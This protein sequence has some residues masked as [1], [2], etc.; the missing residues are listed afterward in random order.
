MK[1]CRSEMANN[2]INTKLIIFIHFLHFLI[3]NFLFFVTVGNDRQDVIGF[4]KGM[5]GCLEHSEM[6]K[7][8]KKSKKCHFQDKTRKKNTV[9]PRK[10][11][12]V[13]K[14]CS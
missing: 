1:Q 4:L 9:S 14:I 5:V 2:T 7:M 8:S 3:V 11:V 10:K 13:F 6:P 12:F